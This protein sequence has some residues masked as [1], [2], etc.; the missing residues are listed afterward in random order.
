M[1]DYIGEVVGGYY[2]IVEKIAEGGYGPTYKAEHVILGQPVCMKCCGFEDPAYD[3][4]LL[5]EA[6]AICNLPLHYEIPAVLNMIRLPNKRLALVMSYAPGLTVEQW[7]PRAGKKFKTEYV[8]IIA[9]R[10]LNALMFLHDHGVVHGDIKPHNIIVQREHTVMVVDYGLSLVKPDASSRAKGYTPFFA[11]P[12]QENRMPLVPESDYYSLG[13]TMIY[14]LARGDMGPVKARRV[15]D[16]TPKA[17]RE[18][19]ERMIVREVI[20]RPSY[21]TENL[22]ETI[23]KVRQEV[24]GRE[25]S[26]R[27][28][29]PGFD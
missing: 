25:Y 22:C 29:F 9:E 24:F 6:K 10:V 5:N 15:P 12:E 27:E 16:G 11:P 23:K 14:M 13:L 8:A 28:P 19:I 2:R 18:F 4:V 1:T 20:H 21:A 26:D 3:Q 17:L 7:I